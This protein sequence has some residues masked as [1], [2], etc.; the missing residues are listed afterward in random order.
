ME[1]ST[2]SQRERLDQFCPECA[3]LLTYDAPNRRFSCKGCGLYLTREQLS[4]LRYKMR[5]P[6]EDDR[7]KKMRQQADYLDWWLNKKEK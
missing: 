1:G 5:T 6:T 2:V 4:D 3:S 7:R